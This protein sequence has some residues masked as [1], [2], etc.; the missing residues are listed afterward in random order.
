MSATEA[1][2]A[3]SEPVAI[4]QSRLQRFI[5]YRLT[6]ASLQ[7]HKL[8]VRRVAALELKPIEFSILVLTD[9]NPGIN[10]RQ[11]GDALDISPPNLVQV[12]DRLNKRKL[13]KRVRSRQ[14]RRIQHIHLTADGVTLLTKAEKD[15][16]EFE[17]GIS[18]LFNATEKKTLTQGLHKLSRL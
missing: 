10:L 2:P 17:D 8:F 18:K 5:G 4:D 13:L 3:T 15:V 9:A 14:D 1:T 11:L 12:V 7:V 6:R 16:A